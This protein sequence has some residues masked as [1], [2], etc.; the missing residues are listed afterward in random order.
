MLV[1]YGVGKRK[2]IFPIVLS[3]GIV[4]EPVWSKLYQNISPKP[5]KYE[6]LTPCTQPGN[7]CTGN[8]CCS[9]FGYCGDTI[10]YWYHFAASRATFWAIAIYLWLLAVKAVKVDPASSQAH[11]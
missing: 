11:L 4:L 8:L 5:P 6:A 9:K 10:E 1:H 3:G 7:P 2:I